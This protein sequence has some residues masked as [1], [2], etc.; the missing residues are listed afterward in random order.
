MTI[1]AALAMAIALLPAI[2]A[3]ADDAIGVVTSVEGRPIVVRDGRRL[4]FPLEPG[5]S[6][7]WFDTLTVR[8]G[9]LVVDVAEFGTTVALDRG[10][11]AVF[12]GGEAAGSY[13]AVGRD[14]VVIEL[15]EGGLT[16]ER[17]FPGG[18][19]P[20][21]G[22]V[23]AVRASAA[24]VVP[25]GA[26]AAVRTAASGHVL[27]SVDAGAAEVLGSDGRSLMALPGYAVEVDPEYGPL[28]NLPYPRDELRAH[29]LRWSA[30]VDALIRKRPLPHLERLA[31]AY[32]RSR[33]EF[34]AAYAELSHL[35]DTLDLLMEA[36]ERGERPADPA[37]AADDGLADALGRLAGWT[38]GLESALAELRGIEPYALPGLAA[39]VVVPDAAGGAAA[40]GLPVAELYQLAADDLSVMHERFATVRYA[41]KLLHHLREGQ[42]DRQAR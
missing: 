1:A 14:A 3:G 21:G 16:L 8:D 4:S 19:A 2:A 17:Q 27:V 10:T 11:T 24:T 33:A 32:L 37:P 20:G 25:Y 13:G 39:A 5:L 23:V 29:E 35:R 30:E 7:E 12:A 40:A 9:R 28:R 38:S 34:L 41:L 15:I 36:A 6:V 18:F 42:A 26:H 22:P 31:G